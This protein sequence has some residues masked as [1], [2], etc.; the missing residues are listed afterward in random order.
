MLVESTCPIHKEKFLREPEDND[1]VL[2]AE[3]SGFSAAMLEGVL[4]DEKIPFLKEGRMGAG[5]SVWIGSMME[6]YSFYVPYIVYDQA[7][8]FY[9]L[10]NGNQMMPD[11]EKDTDDT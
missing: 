2:L 7:K 4:L 6:Q 9:T 5:M 11:D 8:D 10:V 3:L 1:P